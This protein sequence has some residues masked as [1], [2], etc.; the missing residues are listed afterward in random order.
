MVSGPKRPNHGL[1]VKRIKTYS[2]NSNFLTYFVHFGPL[3]GGL[4]TRH[5]YRYASLVEYYP[6]L[7]KKLGGVAKK[8]GGVAPGAIVLAIFGLATSGLVW[9]ILSLG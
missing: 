8:L 3:L 6:K 4:E 5:G 7:M 9:K 1:L 2:Q